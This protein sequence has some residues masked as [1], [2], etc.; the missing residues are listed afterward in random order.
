MTIT[1]RFL[2]ELRISW[3]SLVPRPRPNPMIGPISGE[4]SIA[5]MMTG[6]EL[7]FRPTDA[8]MM[9]VPRIQTFGPRK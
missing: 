1:I 5:P 6:M 2:R 4:I 8:M 3:V 9:A 7:T